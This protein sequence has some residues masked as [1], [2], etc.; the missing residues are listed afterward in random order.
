MR[1]ASSPIRA[2]TLSQVTWDNYIYLPIK[3]TGIIVAYKF[4]F[5]KLHMYINKRQWWNEELSKKFFAKRQNLFTKL[6]KVL[7]TRV[8]HENTRVKHENTRG[9]RW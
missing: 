4:L 5:Y 8:K 3:K 1:K 6:G 9:A 2:G 7:N